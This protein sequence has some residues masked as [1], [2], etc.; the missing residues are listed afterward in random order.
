MVKR[1]PTSVRVDSVSSSFSSGELISGSSPPSPAAAPASPAP[2]GSPAEVCTLA[3]AGLLENE[4]AAT[5]L[6]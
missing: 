4:L 6:E 2:V 5:E 1:S 3:K